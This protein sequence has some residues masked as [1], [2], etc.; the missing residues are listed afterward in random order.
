MGH[1]I[2]SAG[3]KPDMNKIKC[4]REWP[5]PKNVHDVRSFCGFC[6]YY[7]RFIK[8][9]SQR[10]APINRLLEAGQSFVWDEQCEKS[11]QDLKSALTGNEVMAFP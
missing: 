5:V 9:F 8:Q 10:A 3:L 11:F 2:S 6:S 7:R 1:V 4:I